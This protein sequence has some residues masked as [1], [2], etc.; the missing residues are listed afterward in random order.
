MH[1]PLNQSKS[2]DAASVADKKV[3]DCSVPE[4]LAALSHA[5]EK[6][7]AAYSSDD[8]FIFAISKACKPFEIIGMLGYVSLH[9]EMRNK[10]SLAA[11]MEAAAG[12]PMPL[13]FGSQLGHG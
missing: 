6:V 12:G 10:L 11:E 13:D 7:I 1:G 9:V 4:L 2:I 8:A 5:D 3:K